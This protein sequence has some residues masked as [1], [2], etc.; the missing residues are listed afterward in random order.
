MALSRRCAVF[1]CAVLVL[2]PLA[3]CSKDSKRPAAASSSSTPSSASA[4]HPPLPTTASVA[5]SSSGPCHASP[6]PASAINVT[7]ADGDFNGDGTKDTLTV[8]G[9]GTTTQP[10][11]YHVQ[12]ELGGN[13][14]TVDTAITDAATDGNQVVRALGGADITSSAGLP[15][16]GSGAEAFVQVGSGASDHLI[17]VFQLLGCSLTRLV[18]PQG[19]SPSLFAIGGSVTHLDGLRCDG[20]AGGQ[21]LVQLSATS[22]DGVN[23]DTKQTRLQVQDGKFSALGTPITGTVNGSDPS[24][25]GFSALD[26]VGVQSP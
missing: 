18:G 23:Y 13:K 14:G 9:T 22:N 7:H 21:R 1:A 26:C 20:S 19:A 11:P 5:P 6:P 4:S 15:P 10:S 25:Q 17:G 8:Y 3:A 12:I 2:L 24:L 16:D